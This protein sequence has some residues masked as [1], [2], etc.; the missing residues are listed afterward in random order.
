MAPGDLEPPPHRGLQWPD[1][2]A[3]PLRE[4]G[5]ALW[6]WLH[7]VPP[8]ST[9]GAPSCRWCHLAAATLPATDQNPLSL[10]KRVGPEKKFLYLKESPTQDT[11]QAPRI[12]RS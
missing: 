1:R 3:Q 7:F 11:S 4:E 2:R 9:A 8:L 6:S 12:H 5:E 10:L